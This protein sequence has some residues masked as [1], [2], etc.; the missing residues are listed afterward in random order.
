MNRYIVLVI[1]SL[2]I[3]YM[4]DCSIVRPQDVGANTVKSVLT[5]KPKLPILEKLGLMNAAGFELPSMRYS[6]KANFGKCALKHFYADSFAGHQEMMLTEPVKP[7]IAPINNIIDDLKKKLEVNNH[8]VRYIYR[9][10][11]KLMLVDNQF[12]VGDNLEADLG[13]V[14][15]IE[16]SF[17]FSN[18]NAL[19]KFAHEFRKLVKTDR[20]IAFGGLANTREDIE[21]AIEVK[22]NKYIGVNAPRSKVYEK[23]YLVRH[24]GYGVDKSKQAPAILASK[25]IKTNFIGK[26]ADIVANDFGNNFPM[27][28]TTSIMKKLIEVTIEN[29]NCFI[30]ANVQETDLAGHAMNKNRYYEVLKIVDKY[31][32]FLIKEL[33]NSDILLV[34]ADHGNDPCIGHTKHTR[35]YV[36][37][38]VY[39]K[40]LQGVNFGLK[41]SLQVISRTC[42]HYFNINEP[43]QI[44]D[45]IINKEVRR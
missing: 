26:V 7:D 13:T 14:Y 44:I 41:E 40:G 37:L 1:D 32:E 45:E 20:V 33:D 23:G 21:S 8:S 43:G 15:N 35:E 28:D 19:L 34:T 36:P 27:V 11:I 9:K 10:G 39:K 29:E 2:G 42:L 3:G 16:T 30:C 5:N 24:L 38:L 6:E 22:E 17:Q 4:D 12:Y 18:F 31:L 25:G